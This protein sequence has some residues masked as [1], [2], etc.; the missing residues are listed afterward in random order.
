MS[1]LRDRII[2]ADPLLAVCKPKPALAIFQDRADRVRGELVPAR[3]AYR[4]T[5][6]FPVIRIIHIVIPV[7]VFH[8]E[9]VFRANSEFD[10]GVVGDGGGV[11]GVKKRLDP[12]AVVAIEPKG[13]PI[14]HHPIAVPQDRKHIGIGQA[15]LFVQIAKDELLG[16]VLGADGMT[17][18]KAAQ[19]NPHNTLYYSSHTHLGSRGKSECC[20]SRFL[21]Y[22][23]PSA[24]SK[25]TKKSG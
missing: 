16:E 22:P 5:G 14:P 21:Q 23:L 4:T 17:Q 11:F 13:C 7:D 12:R 1:I 9:L 24:L 8:P 20:P 18:R 10:D 3:K 15:E 19:T 6:K 25:Q 2:D